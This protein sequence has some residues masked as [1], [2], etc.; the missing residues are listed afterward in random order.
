MPPKHNKG[1]N[2]EIERLRRELEQTQRQNLELFRFQQLYQQQLYAQHQYSTYQHAQQN[3]AV[4]VVQC[5]STN[6]YHNPDGINIYLG[7]SSTEQNWQ[8]NVIE[9]LR[10]NQQDLRSVFTILEGPTGNDRNSV[11]KNLL[12]PQILR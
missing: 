1:S 4:S 8:D 6:N 10:Q 7:G 11:Q 12:A 9:K 3:H 2:A 5:P